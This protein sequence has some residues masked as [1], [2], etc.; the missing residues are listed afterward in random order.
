M[1]NYGQDRCNQ[2][3][4][5]PCIYGHPSP[6]AHGTTPSP[7]VQRCHCWEQPREQRIRQLL[8]RCR[9]QGREEPTSA[10]A[11]S[12]Y[13]SWL[14]CRAWMSASADLF[15]NLCFRFYGLFNGRVLSSMEIISALWKGA[16]TLGAPWRGHGTVISVVL[17]AATGRISNQESGQKAVL[18][19]CLISSF[20]Y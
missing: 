12:S 16:L 14:T 8:R 20:L 10:T 6:I 9:G 5:Q 17:H 15:K 13:W 1:E 18:S 19:P 4:N 3:T 7:A 2:L 11:N